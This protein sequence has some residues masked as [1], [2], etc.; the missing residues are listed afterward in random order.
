MDDY[1]S[2]SSGAGDIETN[3]LLGYASK[4]PTGDDFSQLGGHPIWL[5]LETTP[6]GTLAACKNCNGLLSLLLQLN[7]DLP[8]RFPSHQRRLYLLGCK[9]KACRRKNGSIRGIRAVKASEERVDR[10]K[11]KSVEPAT[12]TQAQPQQNLGAALFG[13]QPSANAPANPFSTNSGSNITNP[14]AKSAS[15]SS[16]TAPKSSEPEKLAE[17]FAQKARIA[18]PPQSDI[19][20]PESSEP[21][22]EKS[23]F[24]EPFPSY[25]IDAEKEYLEAESQ[26]IPSNARV[27]NSADGEGSGGSG[28]MKGVFESSMDKTFQKFADRLSQNP[29]QVLRYEYGGQALLYSKNDATGKLLASESEQS[30]AKVQVASRNGPSSKMPK[31]TNCGAARTFELQLTPH[32]ITELEADDMSLDGMDWG[33]IIMGVCHNDCQQKGKKVNEVGYVEEWVGVQ[34]EELEEKRK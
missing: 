23:A 34:W 11:Q 14:F 4:E 9:N 19:T 24:P 29:E 27:D 26:D 13:V 33:T 10:P 30:N 2:D 20:Q 1:D 8:D 17:T 18:S 21:W 25:Y 15:S 32:A 7:A 31:C 5:D 6:S 16:S 28:D 22:P 3:V 12:T